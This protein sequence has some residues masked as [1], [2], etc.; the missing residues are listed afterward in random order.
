LDRVIT[1]AGPA[2][3]V[4]SLAPSNTEILFAIGAGAQVVGREE[5]SNYPAEALDVPSVGG[6]FG[7]YDTEAM[8][9][10][11]P[12][13][14][15]AANLTTLEQIQTM[16]DLGMTVF[17]L[18]NPTDLEGMYQNLMTAA[19]LTGHEDEAAA[20]V[21]VLEER[22]AA[23]LE[24]IKM[25]EDQPLVFYE[26]DSTDPAA[27]WTAGLGTFIDTLITMAGGVN[28]GSEYEGAWIQIS[29]EEILA[30]DPALI[31][32]GDSIWG[33]TP[34]S[35]AERAGWEALTAV[36]D[37]QVVPFNDDLVS[38]PGPRMVDGLEE[39]AKLIHPE[40]FE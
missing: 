36:Q 9:A 29:I 5:F 14:V 15:L 26:L 34:E 37:G 23:V 33:I 30:Q 28:F 13:L 8:L 24:V 11:E 10:L 32:L 35:V 22:V 31:V 4:I 17:M 7:D 3:R 20:V 38:R 6:S 16:E 39:L 2:Q 21:G 12:D 25:A 40:L 1:L 18:S 27:P 19:Q